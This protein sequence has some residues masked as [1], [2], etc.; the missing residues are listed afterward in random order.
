LSPSEPGFLKP[1]DKP[2][3]KLETGY[4]PAPGM[5]Q[6]RNSPELPPKPHPLFLLLQGVD[7]RHT[8]GFAQAQLHQF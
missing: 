4:Q 7:G 6:I 8:G 2:F 5:M 1:G 3:T